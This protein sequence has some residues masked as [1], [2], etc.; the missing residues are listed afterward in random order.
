MGDFMKRPMLFAAVALIVISIFSLYLDK[1]ALI[2]PIGLIFIAFAILFFKSFRQ[3]AVIAFVI[4]LFLACTVSEKNKI[5]NMDKYSGIS[6]T[7][8][9]VATENSKDYGYLSKVT[10]KNI[11]RNKFA[12][13]EKFVLIYYNNRKFESGE[14]FSADVT[15][16]S[17]KNSEYR[18]GNYAD[19]IYAQLELDEYNEKLGED[20]FYRGLQKVR[21]YIVDTIGSALSEESAATMCGITIGNKDYF[22]NKFDSNVRSSGVSHAMV[23]SGLHLAIILGGLFSFLEK[24]FYNKYLKLIL[25]L[26]SVFLLVAI[27]GFTMSVIRAGIMFVIAA[28]APVFSRDNDSLNSLSTAMI[29]ILI[30]SPFAI[31]SV[32]LQL[33][34][35]ATFGIIVLAPF[36]INLIC[37]K[38]HIKNRIFIEIISI[39]VNTLSSTVMTLPVIINTF[40]SVSV[41]S[42][43]TNILIT[44]AIT[45]SLTINCIALVLSVIPVLKIISNV[46]FMIVDIL[47][48]YINLCIN[49]FGSLKFAAVDIDKNYCYLAA[50]LIVILILII[51][52]CKK[53]EY[54]IQSKKIKERGKKNV[55]SI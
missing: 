52:T 54:L 30:F 13:E 16:S 11:S 14:V 53:R 29:L 22:S 41:V 33:S 28:M 1:T 3:I 8:N 15:V 55:D 46:L 39:L 34:M 51:Y 10:V 24:L 38:F 48:A 20:K 12:G 49:Y 36:Y 37:E 32:S 23:V 2:I 45:Y 31:F 5:S 21:N 7:L 18:N 6:M 26:A 43:I 25:S 40:G 35:L 4:V 27:C 47:T 17:L 19:G 44:Y 9:L 50:G 42:P